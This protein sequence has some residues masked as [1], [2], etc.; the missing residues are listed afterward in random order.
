MKKIILASIALSLLFVGIYTYE[1]NAQASQKPMKGQIVSLNDVVLGEKNLQ[2][3]SEKATE[4]VERGSP[5]VFL[6][7]KKIYFVQ[8]TD[9]SFA[10]RKL[11]NYAHNKNVG[12]IGK[13][14]TVSG[15]NVI[16]MTHIDSIN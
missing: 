4:L 13:T 7:N 11:A 14:R 2:L 9:G 16:V 10:F 15:I 3:T 6:F 5:L 8:E 1:I 12:I